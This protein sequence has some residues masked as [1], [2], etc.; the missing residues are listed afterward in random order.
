MKNTS[1]IHHFLEQ[2]AKKTPEKPALIHD[3]KR[4]TF[5][6]L[7]AA[8][9]NLAYHLSTEGVGGGSRVLLMLDN[10]F[11]Y[12][13]SYYGI[14]KTGAAVV[15]INS[16]LKK[17]SLERIM[18]EIEPSVVIAPAKCQRMLCDIASDR[19]NDCRLIIPKYNKSSALHKDIITGFEEC[20]SGHHGSLN[21][22]IDGN[23]LS[24]I[25]YTSGSL[26]TPKGVMLSHKN[27]VANTRSICTYLELTEKDIQMVVLPFYYVMGK[28]LLNTHMAVGGTVVINNKFA[29]PATVISEMIDLKVTG[30]SGVPSTFAYL[31]HRSPLKKMR[32]Q[33]DSLRYC[34][35]AGGHMSRAVKMAL[36]DALP[37]HTKLFI[38]YGATEAS[39]RLTYLHPD[40]FHNKIDSIGRPIPGVKI[41]V[42]KED[43]TE[44]GVGE[45][46][47]IVASGENIMQG[48]WR[49]SGL[50]AQKID[51]LGYHTGD[52]GFKDKDGFF[53]LLGRKDNLLKVGGHRINPTE[54]E[55]TIMM[56]DLV[57]EV[58]V[59]GVSDE[60]LGNKIVALAAAQ[61]PEIKSVDI[62]GYCS[63]KLPKHK[64]PSQ[65]IL[66]KN[67]PKKKNG[68]I[69]KN[70]CEAIVTKA[71]DNDAKD[72]N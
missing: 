39:A 59:I 17:D 41:N 68:K 69:D 43:R 28:S 70:Q 7:D 12:V 11:E 15:P 34:T 18:T 71:L 30:F 20:I 5:G 22:E 14:L 66:V 48:Y 9:D 46:G 36:K 42:I 72:R 33:L 21:L 24:S 49:D 26:G 44:A 3:G 50:T 35:Q 65:V 56:S 10:C 32:N 60:L 57:I 6:E 63:R 25:I 53:F 45:E 58:I 19:F 27:I 51:S 62:L 2:S 47:E 54:I 31:L 38:M 40:S 8:A 13:A 67:L 29:F 1:L 64:I 23:S 61:H 4:V 16:A 37:R 55:D 52:L